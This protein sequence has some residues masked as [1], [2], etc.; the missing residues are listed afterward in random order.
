MLQFLLEDDTPHPPPIPTTPAPPR[1]T[2]SV[3]EA[4]IRCE[5]SGEGWGPT[6]LH[7]T[8]TTA[9][10]AAF[11]K[12]LF[13]PFVHFSTSSCQRQN[14]FFPLLPS[15]LLMLA[16]NISPSS[17][18]RELQLE[19]CFHPHVKIKVEA[20]KKLSW[21]AISTTN[22]FSFRFT[23]IESEVVSLFPISFTQPWKVTS[24]FFLFWCQTAQ[25]E[26]EV[27]VS[28]RPDW[29]VTVRLFGLLEEWVS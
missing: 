3:L 1:L 24:F 19:K 21:A 12:S 5:V 26:R 16:I 7:R 27:V 4:K 25:W 29:I 6:G 10:A 9:A 2:K 23:L 28:P 13:S 11:I 8:D 17:Q 20:K 22:S 15:P 14:T 18:F